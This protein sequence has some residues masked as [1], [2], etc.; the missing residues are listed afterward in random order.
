MLRHPV[1]PPQPSSERTVVHVQRSRPPPLR[2]SGPDLAAEG[3]C[4]RKFTAAPGAHGVTRP[5]RARRVVTRAMVTQAE[6]TGTQAAA[7][8]SSSTLCDAWA[9]KEVES[10][11][12][13]SGIHH[14]AVIC[15]SLERSLEF[16]CGLLGAAASPCL[17]HCL[18]KQ[19]IAR[20][21][22]CFTVCR[23]RQIRVDGVNASSSIRPHDQQGAPTPEPPVPRGLAVD[24]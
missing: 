14:V 3:T 11:I 19:R 6:W 8:D 12:K 16:Y 20:R 1:L 21:L 23:A 2:A 13:F 17:L 24:R 7:A 10:S 4:S 18:W 5:V 15:A 22:C 9:A